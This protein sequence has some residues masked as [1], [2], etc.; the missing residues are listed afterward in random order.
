M[1][2]GVSK[3]KTSRRDLIDVAL[4]KTK[5]DIA[6]RGGRLVNV[7]SA[8]IYAADVSIKGDRIAYVGNIEHTVG[9]ETHVIQATGNYLVPGL[10]DGHIHMYHSYM[11]ATQFARAALLHGSTA[12][13]D[14]FY[15]PGIVAGTRAIKFILEEFKKTPLKVIFLLPT[16]SYLQNRE[17]GLS[18]TPESPSPK[19]LAEIL[20]WP[21]CM[22]LEEPPYL[23]IIDKDAVFLD[24][25]QTTLDRGKVVTGHASGIDTRGLNA[26]VA[27]GALTDH[28]AVKAEEAVEKARA[29]LKILMRYGSGATDVP[30]LAKAITE[31]G[32]DPRCF[33]FCAD[34]AAP[35]KL[36]KEGEIDE[37][38]RHAIAAGIDPITAIQ[39]GTLNVAE[40]FKVSHDMGCIAPGRFADILFVDDLPSFKIRQVMA[41]GEIVVQGGKTTIDVEQPRYPD[42]MYKT[43]RLKRP[44]APDDFDVKVSNA[45]ER[46]EAYVIGVTDGSLVTEKRKATLNVE[47]GH[48]KPDLIRDVVKI[49]MVDRFLKTGAVGNAF[50]QGYNLREGAYGMSVNAVCENIAVVGSNSKDMSVVTNR[51][52]DLG[53]G[54]VAARNGE[55]RAEVGLP[56]LGLLSDKPMEKFLEEL[57]E[58]Y[59]TV[60]NFGCTLNYPISTLEFC[61]ACGEIGIIKICDEG[62]LD[63]DKRKVID[64]IVR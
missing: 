7:L 11:N 9:P 24:M 57:D 32:I 40:I 50:V 19:E 55:V 58:F 56:L 38:I 6:I 37:N 33:G 31:Y 53:G 42:W 13:A 41:S 46:V 64:V 51:I 25:F 36:I 22:G 15:G 23:P 26:Y 35:E 27:A 5:A 18:P 16:L 59:A 28:E 3:M 10:I 47:N 29:G 63:V 44:S 34:L 60:R 4:G 21:E 48:V 17:L 8:E 43:V 62:L 61:C 30:E 49:A 45:A 54:M 14:A 52:A 39:I 1:F 12:T 2:D 20:D